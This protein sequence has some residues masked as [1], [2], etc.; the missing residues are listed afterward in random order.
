MTTQRTVPTDLGLRRYDAAAAKTAQLVLGEY[1]TSFGWATRLLARQMRP[2]IANVYG[3][4]RI[5]DEIVD[6]PAHAAGLDVTARARLL[7][8]LEAEVA[9]AREAGYSSNLI[10]HAFAHTANLFGIDERLTAPFFASM[11]ADLSLVSCTQQEFDSYVYGSA[12]VVGLMC[13][14][15]F[16]AGEPVEPVRLARLEA[17]ARRLGAAFQKINFLRDLGEDVRELGRSYFPNV[18]DGRLDE[19]AKAQ[20][21]ASIRDDLRVAH[22]SVPSLPVGARAAVLTALRLFEELTDRIERTPAALVIEQRIRVPDHVKARI[23]ALA[24]IEGRRR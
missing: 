22:E 24:V 12:E 8:A 10:V 11:R 4:V 3:L 20:I 18:P 13:L 17:G 7:D 6:G 19:A 1:S 23:V 14:K 5:A 21:T 15:V 9:A 16:L 2:H